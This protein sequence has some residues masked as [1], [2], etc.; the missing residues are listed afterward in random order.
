MCIRLFSGC[1]QT[2]VDHIIMLIT[3]VCRC[4]CTVRRMWTYA[5]VCIPVKL[6]QVEMQHLRFASVSFWGG[7]SV[8]WQRNAGWQHPGTDERNVGQSIR[9]AYVR[10]VAVEVLAAWRSDGERGLY[11]NSYICSFTGWFHI[12][13]EVIWSVCCITWYDLWE[14]VRCQIYLWE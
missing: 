13:F 6:I 11:F 9:C 3:L 4:R 7:V 12:F 1:V 10:I 14:S 2:S 8:W 5:N